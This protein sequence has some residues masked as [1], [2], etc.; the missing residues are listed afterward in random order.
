[1]SAVLEMVPVGIVIAEAPAGEIILGKS[2][3]KSMLGQ[4]RNSGTRMPPSKKVSFHR[5]T[6]R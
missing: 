5:D 1:L 3:V 4:R 2:R 6:A